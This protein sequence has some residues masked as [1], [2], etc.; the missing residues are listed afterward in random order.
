M[1]TVDD[2]RENKRFRNQT[3]FQSIVF[4]RVEQTLRHWLLVATF[5]RSIYFSGSG[6][7]VSG[8][9]GSRTGC[10]LGC[11][12]LEMF[13]VGRCAGRKGQLRRMWSSA[14]QRRQSPAAKRR[15]RSVWLTHAARRRCRVAP[16]VISTSGAEG[17]ST[18]GN[19]A[20]GPGDG[21]RAGRGK[22]AE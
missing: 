14:P 11:W 3:I 9:S 5:T 7:L 22:G 20:G 13:P 15:S 21:A 2:S 6:G 1:Y 8:C 4:T 12:T 10:I 17:V 16:R 19:R 18:G